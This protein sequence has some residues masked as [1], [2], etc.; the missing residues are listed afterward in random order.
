MDDNRQFLHCCIVATRRLSPRHGK[1]FSERAMATLFSG[2]TIL[3]SVVTLIIVLVHS[4]VATRKVPPSVPWA[5]LERG[6]FSKTRACIRELTAGLR[7][8]KIGYDQVFLKSRLSLQTPTLLIVSGVVQ[9]KG[10][11]LCDPGSRLSARCNDTSGARIV[12][13]R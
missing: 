8:L 13:V 9:S 2:G 12:D 11:A 5:G 7:T 10:S 6:S 3:V 4:R 1:G